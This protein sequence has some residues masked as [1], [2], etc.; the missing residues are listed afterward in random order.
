MVNPMTRLRHVFYSHVSDPVRRRSGKL[1]VEVRIAIAPDDKRRAID[2]LRGESLACDVAEACAIPV[3]R[4]TKGT[5]RSYPLE[6][7][8]RDGV[9]KPV[10]NA[11]AM[12]ETEV[13]AGKPPLGGATGARRRIRTSSWRAATIFAST[14]LGRS[15]AP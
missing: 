8:A 1:W 11:G 6:K 12:H 14:P 10:G 13:A 3:E 15:D 2:L 5:L 9:R 7:I 4:R